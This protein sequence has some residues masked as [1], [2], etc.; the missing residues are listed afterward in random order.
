ML[1]GDFP[2][3]GESYKEKVASK[4]YKIPPEI[5]KKLTPECKDL[6]SRCFEPDP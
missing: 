4:D 3:K 2:F 6:I 1:V 5:E